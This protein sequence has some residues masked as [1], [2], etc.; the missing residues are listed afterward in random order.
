MRKVKQTEVGGRRPG[1]TMD[2]AVFR[3]G[4]AA[5][6]QPSV[7]PLESTVPG[8]P[9]VEDEVNAVRRILQG[10]WTVDKV[11]EIAS[12]AAE[13]A[14]QANESGKHECPKPACEKGCFYCCH[15][16]NISAAIPEVVAIAVY[17][18]RNTTPDELTQLHQ[19]IDAHA[20]RMK[21]STSQQRSTMRY[22]CPLLVGGCCSVYEVRPL[23]CRGWHSLDVSK[24]E[25]E[26][27]HPGRGVEIPVALPL[28]SSF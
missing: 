3:P 4:A 24:C 1:Q 23:A 11:V 21:G 28:F 18:K 10:E 22:P 9:L 8:D 27:H 25:E 12:D 19:R 2:G 13:R 17:V 5:H 16:V 15:L 14:R 26:F 20:E 6:N 7:T